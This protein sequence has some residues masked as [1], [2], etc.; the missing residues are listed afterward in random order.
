MILPMIRQH[1]G[2]LT[3]YI[4]LGIIILATI[5]VLYSNRKPVVQ[6]QDTEPTIV[7]ARTRITRIVSDCLQQGFEE[8]MQNIGLV[9]NPDSREVIL[10]NDSSVAVLYNGNRLNLP[11]LNEYASHIGGGSI[12]PFKQCIADIPSIPNDM[13]IDYSGLAFLVYFDETATSM[14]AKIP[15]TVLAGRGEIKLLDFKA[16]APVAFLKLHSI[17][18]NYLLK[19]A[20]DPY[21]IPFDPLLF[22][23]VSSAW[24]PLDSSSILI[25][26]KDP[27]S[28]IN[29][30]PWPFQFAMKYT[31]GG[32][33]A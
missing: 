21:L 17:V 28:S 1:R 12:H 13:T 26:L 18:T 22:Q 3:V 9:G 4:I 15:V 25:Q 20:S 32:E 7:E 8:S 2:Q 24:Y 5:G 33:R 14:Q 31:D 6:T 10:F 30:K 27:D 29:G 11:S 23:D 19:A 16:S